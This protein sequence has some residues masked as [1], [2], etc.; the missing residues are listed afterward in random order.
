MDKEIQHIYNTLQEHFS[1]NVPNPTNYPVCFMYYLK[2][3]KEEIK[4]KND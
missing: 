2:C 4:H 1:I 3:Y